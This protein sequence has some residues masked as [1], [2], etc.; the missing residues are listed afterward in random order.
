MLPYLAL[1]GVVFGV[2]LMPAF[3]PPTW[4]LLVFFR[5]QSQIPAVPLVL[6]GALAAASGRLVLAFGSR[7]FRGRLSTERL[8][9]LAAARDALEGG[10]KRALAGLSLFALSPLPSAQ[11]FVAAGLVAAPIAS[12]TAAF[13]AGRLVSYSVY[14]TAASAAKHSLGSIIASSFSSP[15]GIALQVVMLAGLVVLIRV[16]WAR[17]LSRRRAILVPDRSDTRAKGACRSRASHPTDRTDKPRVLT[18]A[19]RDWRDR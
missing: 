9:H 6:I 1:A 3:G 5:L 7:R 14:V 16:D 10:P 13:F 4:S 2:N 17:L 12:L 18:R 8:E 11:L 19:R 15:A